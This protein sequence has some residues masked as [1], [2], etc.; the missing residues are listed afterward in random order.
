MESDDPMDIKEITEE[1]KEESTE[2]TFPE[3][4][5]KVK[6][7]I[8]DTPATVVEVTEEHVEAQSNDE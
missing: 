5:E 2:N 4:I 7:P 1:N 3:I 6:V 8:E